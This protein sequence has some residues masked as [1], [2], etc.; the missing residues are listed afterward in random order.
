MRLGRLPI[1]LGM[2]GLYVVAATA[3]SAYAFRRFLHTSWTTACC[4]AVPG[5]LSAAIALSEG[6][7]DERLVALMHITRVIMVVVAIPLIIR[8]TGEFAGGLGESAA[9]PLDRGPAS[10]GGRGLLEVA[11]LAGLVSAIGIRLNFKAPAFLLIA[12]ILSAIARLAGWTQG[13]LPDLPLN[14]AMLILGSAIGAGCG[15]MRGRGMLRLLAVGFG[16]MAGLLALAAGFAAALSA[17]LGV[18]FHLTLLFFAPGGIAEMSLIAV[19]LGIDPPLVVLHQTLRVL[20][21]LVVSPPL[22]AFVARFDRR[23]GEG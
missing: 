16:V 19:A 3:G 17:T 14:L 18:P 13:Q 4:A 1:S 20:L 15:V 2:L 12:V 21:I 22:I 9:W 8:S 23:D 5:G 6:R 10:A 11:G 7:G